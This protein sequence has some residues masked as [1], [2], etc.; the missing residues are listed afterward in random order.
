MAGDPA[1]PPPS[2]QRRE[3][4]QLPGQRDHEGRRE[5]QDGRAGRAKRVGP[6]E[7]V[8]PVAIA[9]HVKDDGRALILYTRE[10]QPPR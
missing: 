2:G 8:G 5:P 7:R 9:R 10:E 4:E 6:D 1:E 3:I